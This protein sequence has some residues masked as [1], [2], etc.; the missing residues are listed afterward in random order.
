MR[1][2]SE[3]RE[4]NS[5]LH[6][7]VFRDGPTGLYNHRYFQEMLEW[8]IDRASRYQNSFS[9]IMFDLDFFKTVNDN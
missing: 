8:E 9:L 5:K 1:L 3:L 6:E 2:A 7:L 4:T